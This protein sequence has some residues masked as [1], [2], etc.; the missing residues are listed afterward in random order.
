MLKP[1]AVGKCLQTFDRDKCL[2]RSTD[3]DKGKNRTPRA[4]TFNLTPLY[5]FYICMPLIK[6]YKR[7]VADTQPIKMNQY[8]E[9]T[10]QPK[11]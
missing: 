10:T 2:Q 5:A 9:S 6:V 3:E 11:P 1:K 8:L 7:K 4:L